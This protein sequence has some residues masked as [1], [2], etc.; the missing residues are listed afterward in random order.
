MISRPADSEFLLYYGQYIQ[1]VGDGDVVNSLEKQVGDT[2]AF[3]AKIPESRRGFRYA[4]DKWSINEVVGH[5][6]DTER[7]MSHRALRFARND[8]TPLPGFEQDDYVPAAKFDDYPLSDLAREFAAVRKATCYLFRHLSDDAS[9]RTG[10]A[11][12]AE[13]SVRALAYIIA[14]HELHHRKVLLDR[15][16]TA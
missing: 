1:L 16:L 7:V 10:M 14:G 9:R 4:P 15:Y 3:L 11:N 8:K 13:I 6:I 5:M 12:G 2:L